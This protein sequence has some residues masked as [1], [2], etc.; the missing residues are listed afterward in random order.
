L[1]LREYLADEAATRAFGARLSRRLTPGRRWLISLAGELG[2]GKTTLVR[3]LLEGLGHRGRVRSPTYTLVEPYRV[4]GRDLLH[5]D[6]YRLADPGELEYLGFVDLLTPTAI[7]LVEWPERG[8]DL[9]PPADL[10]VELEYPPEAGTGA[11]GRWL[12]LTAR[13]A[14]GEGVLEALAARETDRTDP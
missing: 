9:L 12:S 11:A 10:A 13:D 5:L 3:G 6:L 2:A 7:A 4:D 1:T 8:G 14:D